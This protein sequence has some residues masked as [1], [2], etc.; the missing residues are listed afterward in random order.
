M[1]GPALLARLAGND[2]SGVLAAD[3]AA[4]ASA[5][6]RRGSCRLLRAGLGRRLLHVADRR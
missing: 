1:A 3:D 5:L 6:G 2:W 4:H